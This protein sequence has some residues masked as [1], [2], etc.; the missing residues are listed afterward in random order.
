MFQVSLQHCLASSDSEDE[1]IL[2]HTIFRHGNRA[3]SD[4]LYSRNP[5]GAES[6]Y[7]PYGYGQLNN[8]GKLTEYKLGQALRERY[9]SFLGPEYSVNLIDA[10]STNVTRTKMSILAVF[11]GLFPPTE[12]LLWNQ[13]LL[14]QPITY[15]LVA[16]DKVLDGRKVCTNYNKAYKKVVKSDEI[17]AALKP[18][19]EMFEY[20][21]NRTG[22]ELVITKP[23][24]VANLYAELV[25][26]KAYG[27]PIDDFFTEYL[28]DMKR[29]NIANYY[30]MTNTSKLRRLV[31]GYLI[32]KIIVD[33][34]TKVG[35]LTS[36]VKLYMYSA[37]DKTIGTLLAS[38]DIFEDEDVPNFGSYVLVEVW[39]INGIF[40]Y[41]FYYQNYIYD[42]PVL[43]KIPGCDEFC[44]IEDLTKLVS[45]ILPDDDYCKLE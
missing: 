17:Q 9:D 45:N 42:E 24:K 14:W 27:Y 19:Q 7:A 8:E 40:G 3:I 26:Q 6:Y 16:Y 33:T 35:N 15:D 38:L 12:D 36:P 25:I 20:L 37:H 10:R 43:K 21:S 1:L 2:V 32:K 30:L 44:P 23:K 41:K 29:I 5:Y 34:T 31:S 13:N 18:Y 22:L 11:A 4:S 39:K 28:E